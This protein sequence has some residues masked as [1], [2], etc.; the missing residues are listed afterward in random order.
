MLRFRTWRRARAFFI[1]AA[2]AAV[3]TMPVRAADMEVNID[4]FA[5]TPKELTVKAG[6]TIVFRNR[7]LFIHLRQSRVLRLFLPKTRKRGKLANDPAELS[8]ESRVKSV[9]GIELVRRQAQTAA[10]DPSRHQDLATLSSEVTMTK[11]I[12][13]AL[14]IA[15]MGIASNGAV[16]D[17]TKQPVSHILKQEEQLLSAVTVMAQKDPGCNCTV[18]SETRCMYKSQCSHDGGTCG[19]SCDP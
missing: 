2:L 4:N 10:P 17:E 6:T 1:A 9:D 18:G 15:V 11:I 16:A 19:T 13:A 7:E 5:F 14:A 12:F 3:S 8:G